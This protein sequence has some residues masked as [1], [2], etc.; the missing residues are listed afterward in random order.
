MTEETEL[1][2]MHAAVTNGDLE[3]VLELIKSKEDEYNSIENLL[4]TTNE[5]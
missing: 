1:S 4:L 2:Q 5:R 3:K